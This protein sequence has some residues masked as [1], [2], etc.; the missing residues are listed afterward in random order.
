MNFRISLLTFAKKTARILRSIAF[1]SKE[2]FGEYCHFNNIKSS[3]C[4]SIYLVFLEFLPIVFC[5]FQC[6]SCTSIEFILKHFI[7][8]MIL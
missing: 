4:I 3:G 2:Q 1:E 6:T 5:S 7:L 8:L